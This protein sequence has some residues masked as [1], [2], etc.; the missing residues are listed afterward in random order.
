MVITTVTNGD[1]PLPFPSGRQV[2]AVG[3]VLR[4]GTDHTFCHDSLFTTT[5]HTTHISE[6]PSCYQKL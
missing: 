5:Y 2:M 3:R 1:D 6:C 4:E